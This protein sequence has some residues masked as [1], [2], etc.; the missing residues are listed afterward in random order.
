MSQWFYS[1]NGAQQGPIGMDQLAEWVRNGQLAPDVPVWREGMA[2]WAPAHTVLGGQAGGSQ[3]PGY[4]APG[5]SMAA[6]GG[7]TQQQSLSYENPN[8][9]VVMATPRA[10]DMLRQTKP[11]VR[12]LSVLMIIGISL[13]VIGI[14]ISLITMMNVSS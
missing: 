2:S 5:A 1:L 6:A 11:W 13:G 9:A 3:T 10:L 14:L 12:F 7:Y 4:A 8:Q